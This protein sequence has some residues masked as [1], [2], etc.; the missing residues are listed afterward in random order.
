MKRCDSGALSRNVNK[1]QCCVLPNLPESCADYVDVDVLSNAYARDLLFLNIRKKCF[2]IA[3]PMISI[4]FMHINQIT[5][6]L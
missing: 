2:R 6:Y 3:I 5:Q 4:L 1:S